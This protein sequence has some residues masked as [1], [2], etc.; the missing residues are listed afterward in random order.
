MQRTGDTWASIIPRQSSARTR[1]SY[2]NRGFDGTGARAV[3]KIVEPIVEPIGLR[4]R[5]L[6]HRLMAWLQGAT[7]V[8]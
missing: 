5:F 1:K 8:E 7:Y 6:M 2:E 4:L 3:K